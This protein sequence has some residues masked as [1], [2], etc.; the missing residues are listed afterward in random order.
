MKQELFERFIKKMYSDTEFNIL[1][2]EIMPKFDFNE[3][4][5]FLEVDPTIFIEMKQKSP[6]DLIDEYEMAWKL[7]IMTG[8][9]FSI[10]II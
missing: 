9:G 10:T 1:S 6:K 5:H 4:G 7:E 8:Y 3:S 2:Y